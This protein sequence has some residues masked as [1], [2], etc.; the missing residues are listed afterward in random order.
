[1]SAGSVLVVTL[2]LSRPQHRLPVFL[3]GFFSIL[4]REV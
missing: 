1:M 3:A 2:G 4:L